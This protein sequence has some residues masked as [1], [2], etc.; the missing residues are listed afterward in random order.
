MKR[1]LLS[2]LMV[3]VM[4]LTCIP[5]GAVS[6][7][8]ARSGPLTYEINKGHVVITD[9]H[10]SAS[11]ELIIPA[12][13]EGYPVTSIRYNAFSYCYRLCSVIIPDSVTSIGDY[14]FYECNSLT[15]V[16]I[17]DSVTTIGDSAFAYCTS[18]T[19]V[20]I[21]DSVTTIEEW[22]FSS[23][24]GLTSV[25]I[26]DSVT[27]IGEYA[28]ALCICLTTVAIPD[29]VTSIGE[30][31]FSFCDSLTS[32]TVAKNNKYYS[33]I[34]GVLFNKD[35]TMLIKCPEERTGSYTIPDSVTSIGDDAFRVCD[36]LTSVTISDS[37]TSIGDYAFSRCDGLTSVT[38]PD[39]VTSIGEKVFINCDSLTSVTISGSITSIGKGVFNGCESLT[40]VIIPN[41]VTSIGEDAFH[42]C[43]SLTS[44]TIPNSVTS[45]GDY[46]F[47]ECTSLTK[48]TIGDSVT[49]IGYAAF[50]E[51]SRLTDVYYAGTEAERAEIAIDANNDNLL[52]ATWHYNCKFV[53]ITA[54]PTTAYAKECATAKVT[55]KAT[56]DGLKYQWYIKNAGATKYS[57]SSVTKAT[58]SATM[59]DK[60]KGRRVYCIITDQYGNQ[61]QSN[62]VLLREAVSITKESA[63][64]AYAKKGAKVSVKVTASGDG[65]K[66]TW[67]IKNDGGSKYSK[68]SVTSATY[69]T[70]M[71]D[72]AKNRRVYCVVK[73]KYGKT[74]QSKTFLLRESVSITTQPKTVSVSKNKT[75]KVTVKASGDGLKYAWYIKNAGQTKYSKSSV[76]KATYSTTMNS[77]S[78][79]R[80]VYCVVTDKYGKTVKTVTVKLKMK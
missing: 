3:T 6:V 38:I 51:C 29:S 55:V 60:V 25:T 40:S 36:N 4:L 34:D 12:E 44:V 50:S 39:S 53:S 20:T 58:Y 78:K 69:S 76:T 45:I 16:T 8:A 57:K 32:I 49:S 13:I 77:K 70:T 43:T 15:S 10:Y 47:S 79:N 54:Q 2:V 23:C 35:K 37:V 67:Y 28:F 26:G 41:S 18:L 22:A 30:G 24:E 56:G 17:G 1:K 66:Y 52:N 11:G 68:S 14:A 46:A 21:P 63:T 62:T 42:N 9:C 7:S 71:S 48:V 64:A 61:V 59:S 19:S 31:V 33:S 27:I 73:D 74:V 5:L 72:K 65:L 80:L 75:A